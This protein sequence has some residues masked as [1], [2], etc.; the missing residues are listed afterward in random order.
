MHIGIDIEICRMNQAGLYTYLWNVLKN[1]DRLASAH[2]ITLFLHGYPGMDEPEPVRLIADH[3]SN[4][5]LQYVW[6]DVPL[7]LFSGH[8]NNQQGAR[9]WRKQIDRRA[10]LPLWRSMMNPGSSVVAQ[11]ARVSRSAHRILRNSASLE[12]DVFHHPAGL[13]F[14]MQNSANVMTLS[15]LIPVHFPHYYFGAD[16]FRESFEKAEQMEIILAYSEYTKYDVA[17]TLGINIENVRVVPLAAHQQYR[18]ISDKSEIRGVLKKYGL[19][20]RPYILHI[21]SLEPRKNLTR[22]VEAF[23]MLKQEEPSFEH[24]LVLV[25]NTAAFYEPIF[26]AIRGL[27]L[28]SDVKW[29]GYVPFGDLPALLNGADLFVFPSIYEG[30]GL[31]PLEAMA[32]GTP[33]ASSNAT[34]LPEVVGDAGL[35]FDPYR[36]KDMA[37]TM[38]RILADSDLR[39]ALRQKGLERARMFSWEKSA[40]ATL[41][42]YEEAWSKFQKK[43]NRKTRR[44][45]LRY[46]PTSNYRQVRNRVVDQFTQQVN[47]ENG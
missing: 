6:Y 47:G 9:S 28:E 41:T 16:W 8:S 17:Q 31:P 22:L 19:L 45:G 3:F 42:A 37:E 15:D 30:F 12:V 29:M 39:E 11:L 27:N 4:V 1:L 38:H 23:H 13:V 20:E 25:G 5:G 2:R 21:G 44:R 18:P 43:A 10:L 7:A 36:I 46:A 32:C 14:P 40:Q 34:S 33:V 26:E 35:L 24:Q